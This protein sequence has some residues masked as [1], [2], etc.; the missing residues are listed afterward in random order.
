MGEMTV[1]ISVTA[2][3]PEVKTKETTS[4]K[5]GLSS[6]QSYSM[7]Q[8]TTTTVEETL[9]FL[10]PADTKGEI[11]YTQFDSTVNVPWQGVEHVTFKD[12]TTIAMNVGGVYEGVYISKISPVFNSNP[13]NPCNCGSAEE[14]LL[15]FEEEKKTVSRKKSLRNRLK[16]KLPIPGPATRSG[17]TTQ[18][19]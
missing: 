5:W 10:Y 19:M 18:Q 16:E 13:C 3:V 6:T 1:S 17:P 2:G 11:M 7:E 14:D 15:T 12:G 8:D 9:Y 4:F